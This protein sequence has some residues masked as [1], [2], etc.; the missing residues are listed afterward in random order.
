MKRAVIL[1]Q[2]I[3]I[4]RASLTL[5]AGLAATFSVTWYLLIGGDLL[6]GALAYAGALLSAFS[7]ERNGVGTVQRW[8]F[9]LTVGGALFVLLESL[10]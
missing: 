1:P 5:M 8:A 4:G 7:L 3:Q 10:R 2:P 6:R 9:G